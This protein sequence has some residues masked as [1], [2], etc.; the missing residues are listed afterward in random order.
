M[1]ISEKEK[2]Q[3]SSKLVPYSY[4]KCENI[5]KMNCGYVPSHWHEEFEINYIISGTAQF[6]C[7]Q[8]TFTVTKG[9]IVFISPNM[10]HSVYPYQDYEQTYDTLV[11]N[12]ELFGLSSNDRSSAAY[13]LPIMNSAYQINPHITSTHPYYNEIKTSI[14]NIFSC[15]K[16]D[17]VLMD[18]LLKSELMKILWLLYENGDIQAKNENKLFSDA[19][20][21]A[22]ISYIE[23][24]FSE[25]ISVSQ[26][27]EAAHLSKS[28]FMK[29][30]KTA[31]GIGA[32]EYI[33]QFRIKTACNF[34]QHTEKAVAQIAFECGYNNLSNFNRQF[35]K[36]VGCS[37][38]E[39][40][41]AAKPKYKEAHNTDELT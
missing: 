34:L 28:H 25:E 14:E 38:R 19:C 16:S 9:D 23:K 1:E 31:T 20:I 35:K 12:G 15:A 37:P 17:N 27:A 30:F 10:L 40:R 2:R 8:E 29:K 4:Y 32:I 33:I 36:T 11:F 18:L 24:N 39:Y 3:H 26:L 22:S 13:L 41:N 6:K 7:A 5:C 21:K